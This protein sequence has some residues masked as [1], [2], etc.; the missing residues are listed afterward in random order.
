MNMVDIANAAV[1]INGLSLDD[2]GN[3]FLLSDKYPALKT[4]KTSG[5]QLWDS[6]DWLGKVD[7]GSC[8]VHLGILTPNSRWF[9][10]NLSFKE[11]KPKQKKTIERIFNKRNDIWRMFDLASM[12]KL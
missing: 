5:E 8:A 6:L 9:N 1:A 3:K 11:L 12:L 7:I 10:C 4:D 2:N